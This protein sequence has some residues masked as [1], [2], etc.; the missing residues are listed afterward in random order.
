M[1]FVLTWGPELGR[2]AARCWCWTQASIV[3]VER[4]SRYVVAR[5]SATASAYAAGHQR[6]AVAQA[7][8]GGTA[9]R[10]PWPLA[11]T[12]VALV[13]DERDR[14]NGLLPACWGW[15]SPTGLSATPLWWCLG[16]DGDDILTPNPATRGHL[17]SAIHVEPV[18]VYLL[19]AYLLRYDPR[20]VSLW[21]QLQD[22]S[23][24][25]ST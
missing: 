13:D 22:G 4:G 15:A 19:L 7:W 5:S 20:H 16:A 18:L 1:Q 25:R 3:A 8:R 2:E 11:G 6:R 14:R 10:R 23:G 17:G 12:D 9:G 24:D 21:D